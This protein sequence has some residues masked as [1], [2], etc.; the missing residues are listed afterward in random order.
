MKNKLGSLIFI[1]TLAACGSDI[2]DSGTAWKLEGDG[3]DMG[4]VRID[5]NENACDFK[6]LVANQSNLET[7]FLDPGVRVIEFDIESLNGNALDNLVFDIPNIG[8]YEFNEASLYSENEIVATGFVNSGRLV[9]ENLNIDFETE[10]VKSFLLKVSLNI[11]SPLDAVSN[12]T[13]AKLLTVGDCDVDLDSSREIEL[14]DR[15]EFYIYDDSR[16]QETL[17]SQQIRGRVPVFGF[18]VEAAREP[19]EIRELSVHFEREDGLSLDADYIDQV[20]LETDF[21]VYEL[22]FDGISGV[23]RVYLDDNS[24]IG[25]FLQGS[26]YILVGIDPTYTSSSPVRVY[27]SAFDVVGSYSDEE[28]VTYYKNEIVDPGTLVTSPSKGFVITD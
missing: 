26:S 23:S 10:S 19:V 13:K 24:E 4:G 25:L 15:G 2:V 18:T 28:P 27:L 6:V 1:S 14:F 7:V 9:F 20:V 5:M 12:I 17:V 11:V 3:E 22:D 16:Y 8:R 21:G